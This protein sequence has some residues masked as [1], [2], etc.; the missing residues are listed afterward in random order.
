MPST[1]P[2]EEWRPVQGYDG[3]ILVS[4]QGRVWF[5]GGVTFGHLHS[6]GYRSVYLSVWSGRVH[7]LVHRLVAFIFLGEP[8]PGTGVVNHLNGDKEDNR[9]LNLEWAS[10]AENLAHSMWTLGN[11]RGLS[12]EERIRIRRK[13]LIKSTGVPFTR[14][15][16]RR[17][18]AQVRRQ[19]AQRRV[20]E[21][22]RAEWTRGRRIWVSKHLEGIRGRLDDDISLPG[23]GFT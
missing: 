17:F 22:N 14:G 9:V 15:E 1:N 19:R 13:L 3:E 4:D 18:E 20:M 5:A 21:E 10:P 11:Q 8:P 2:T 23:L 16:Q 7:V 6:A 12:R